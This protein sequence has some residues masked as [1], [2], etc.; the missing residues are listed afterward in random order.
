MKGVH[1]LLMVAAAWW[2]RQGG[3]QPVLGKCEHRCGDVDVPFPFGL[4]TSC[5]R[6][7]DFLLNCTNIEGG[8]IQLRLGNLRIRRISVSDSTMVA[9]LPEAYECYDQNGVLVNHSSSPAIDLSPNPRYRLSE[10]QNKLT[11]VGCDT[12]AVMADGEGAFR[13]GCVSYCSGK[14][15]FANKTT[16][17][18]IDE[19]KDRIK[20]PCHG[21]CKNTPGSY[22]CKCRLGKRGNARKSCNVS[23]LSIAVP[24]LVVSFFGITMTASVRVTMRVRLKKTNFSQNG[25]EFFLE[26]KVRIFLEL[27]LAKATNNY[28]YRNKLSDDRFS[29]VH[30]GT[31]AGDT[32]VVV[33]KPKD[34]HKSII[35]G[36]F[37]H[38]L[39]FLM[40]RSHRNVVKLKGICLETRIP[41]LVYEYIPNGTLFQHIHQNT[42]TVLKSWED[43][44]RIATEVAL[45][46]DHMHSQAKPPIVHGNIKSANILLDQNNSVKI[47]DLGTLVLISPEHRHIVVTQKKDSLG[48]IDPE[49]LITGMLKTQ[50]DV[51]SFGVVLV[52]LLTRKK[53]YVIETGKNTIHRFISSVKGDTLSEV[54][55]FE[56]ASE[57][58]MEGVRSVAEIAVRCLD[59]SG[60]SRPAMSEVAEQLVSISP[61]SKVE[62]EN[63]DAEGEW[64]AEK[65]S[66]LDEATS[67][68]L[69][70]LGLDSIPSCI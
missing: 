11:V 20:F 7:Q 55:D 5:V 8:G 16:C 51:Y 45:A 19:C 59:Q 4:N 69:S 46:L 64:D 65:V 31:I 47:S 27:E 66:C 60:A 42:S 36:E 56:G 38:E 14:V 40:K 21:K 22:T 10:T 48:Y 61:S 28:N 13:G 50:S 15:D 1:W 68:C 44:F 6:S 18:D 17:S 52:E 62:E 37:Q 34:E 63:E 3:A 23:P 32:V 43:R 12:L 35:N 54:I 57:D 24:V 70:C 41:L 2:L 53:P 9:S 33:K 26:R 49:Y 39:E 29:S 58:E 25:G 30:R 67:S